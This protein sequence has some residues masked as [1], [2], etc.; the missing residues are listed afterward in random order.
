M[1]MDQ[2]F[3]I[4]IAFNILALGIAVLMLVRRKCSGL[5]SRTIW[6]IVPLALL[7]G[8]V[9]IH[10]EYA[11]TVIV[12]L[13]LLVLAMRALERG[14]DAAAGILLALAGLLRAFPLLL[15]VYLAVARYWRA[16]AW[17]IVG[18]V[19]GGGLTIALV[20]PAA[21]DFFNA[22]SSARLSVYLQ[23]PANL[24]IQAVVWRCFLFICRCRAS[25]LIGLMRGLAILSIEAV[26][27]A[28]AVK[29]T[30]PLNGHDPE[31]GGF[32]L[33]IVL[34]IML[35]PLVWSF[36]LV[37]LLIPYAQIVIGA[38]SG[39]ASM[40]AILMAFGSY[41]AISVTRTM[42]AGV[43]IGGPFAA[44][45]EQGAWVSL[46]M[47][48]VAMYWFVV[49]IRVAA[50]ELRLRSGALSAAPSATTN[51]AQEAPPSTM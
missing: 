51:F 21:F 50:P 41:G 33:W 29:A 8:P 48:Y 11:Q 9:A 44:L 4:W 14:M 13:A 10:F 39:R 24:A 47:A 36:Y 25:E 3:W 46:L 28:V 6:T 40:R 26:L 45:L 18:L 1:P 43:E 37:L 20:G 38:Y 27:L 22:I 2:A 42:G 5:D 35:S 12:V 49:D 16:L 17:A 31:W 7:Y 19:I 15:L 23:D 30:W 34:A 32:S